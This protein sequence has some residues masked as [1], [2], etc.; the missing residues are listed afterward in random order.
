MREVCGIAYISHY[1]RSR[2]ALRILSS[3]DLKLPSSSA[4]ASGMAARSM[5]HGQRAMPNSGIKRSKIIVLEAET[6][7]RDSRWT[8][9]SL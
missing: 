8:A 9:G 1:F 2:G 5:P 4:A 7:T 3:A 6:L